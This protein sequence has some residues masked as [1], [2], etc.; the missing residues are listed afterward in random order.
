MDI[1]KVKLEARLGAME[2]FITEA[3]RLSY[4]LLDLSVDDIE[5]MHKR[6]S[7]QLRTMSMPT[8]DPAL[9]DLGAA[10]IQEAH[11]RLQNM[12]LNSAKQHQG[13]K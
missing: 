4:A 10:V 3:M 6:K 11:E 9:G 2:I 5:A 1:E 12:I 13:A 8:T 7:E